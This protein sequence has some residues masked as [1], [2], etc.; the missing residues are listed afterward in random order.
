MD[1]E[2]QS[3]KQPDSDVAEL[4]L[5]QM[6]IHWEKM[7]QNAQNSFPSGF[8]IEDGPIPL[9]PFGLTPVRYYIAC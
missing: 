5:E 3:P 1:E 9:P 7:M 2:R 8:T 4:T 6:R